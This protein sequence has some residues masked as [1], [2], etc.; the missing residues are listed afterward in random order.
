GAGNSVRRR[1]DTLLPG[2]ISAEAGAKEAVD[3]HG[4]VPVNQFAIIEAEPAH[5]CQWHLVIRKP[6]S[7]LARH[8]RSSCRSRQAATWAGVA[9]DRRGTCP[10]Q[11][12]GSRSAKVARFSSS[13]DVAGS[14]IL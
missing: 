13:R 10:R 5:Q 1:L 6:A 7:R 2:L 9:V 3:F 8:Q 12:P 14:T 11:G 4:A